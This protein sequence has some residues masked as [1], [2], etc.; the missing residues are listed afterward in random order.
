MVRK[1]RLDALLHKEE[2]ERPQRMQEHLRIKGVS[3]ADKVIKEHGFNQNPD[4]DL[5]RFLIWTFWIGL[6]ILGFVFLF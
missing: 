1:P 3:H 5:K 2:L 6:L 4:N